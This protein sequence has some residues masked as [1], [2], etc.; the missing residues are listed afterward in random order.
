MNMIKIM[1]MSEL[2]EMKVENWKYNRPMDMNRLPEIIKYMEEMCRM[3]GIIYLAKKDEIYYCYDGIHRYNALREVYRKREE[4]GDLLGIMNTEIMVNVDIMEYNEEMIR[5]R[6]ININSSI[7]VPEV[8][9]EAERKLDKIRGLEE[10]MEYMMKRYS[11][12]VRNTKRVMK[13]NVSKTELMDVLKRKMEED[14]VYRSEYWIDRIEK[15]NNR[16]K[17]MRYE[18]KEGKH[19]EMNKEMNKE[20]KKEEN[21]LYVTKKQYEKCFKNGMYIFMRDEW[22]DK[23]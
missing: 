15:E 8:Y 2:M 13:P 3:E 11:E 12:F 4:F 17:Y 6:F 20:M 16:M 10:V 19:K 9:T 1:R 7:P 5:K 23:L 14:G 21:I 22:R 18:I